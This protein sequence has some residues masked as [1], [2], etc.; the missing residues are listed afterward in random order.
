MH[1]GVAMGRDGRGSRCLL[2]NGSRGLGGRRREMRSGVGK[3]RLEVDRG[4]DIGGRIMGLGM[5][6]LD[7]FL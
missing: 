5:G 4:G 3:L 7:S 2:M 1:W 6:M